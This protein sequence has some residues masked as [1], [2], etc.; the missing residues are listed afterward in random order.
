MWSDTLNGVGRKLRS[1]LWQFE[2]M[3]IWLAGDGLSAISGLQFS[4]F[5]RQRFSWFIGQRV[6]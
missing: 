1:N 6:S 3:T 5:T 4:W 2:G